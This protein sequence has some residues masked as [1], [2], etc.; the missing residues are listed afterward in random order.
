M[1]Q[2]YREQPLRF[3]PSSLMCTKTWQGCYIYGNIQILIHQPSS[4]EAGIKL[5]EY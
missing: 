2:I 1:L 4:W 5:P 3:E